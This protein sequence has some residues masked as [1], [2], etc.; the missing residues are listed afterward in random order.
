MATI[1]YHR[2]RLG[3]AAGGASLSSGRRTPTLDSGTGRLT[4]AAA[5]LRMSTDMQ[6]FST[7]G[8]LAHI[9][10]YAERRGFDVVRVYED[11]GRSG[12]TVDGR[13]AFRRLI[14][15][16]VSGRADFEAILVYD[17]SRWGRFQ[18]ADE[19]AHLERFRFNRGRIL[20]RRR[21]LRPRRA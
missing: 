12:L 20:P 1:R 6:S 19:G 15:D 17:I 5:Y 3:P 10:I 4:R 8:Q 9:Q 18:D 13:E 2:R 21:S 14:D 11:A 7:E 16:V